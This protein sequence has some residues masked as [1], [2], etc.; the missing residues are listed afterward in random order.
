MELCATN[1]DIYSAT[2]SGYFW[3]KKVPVSLIV[4]GSVELFDV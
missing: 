2:A 1:E 4:D 3:M